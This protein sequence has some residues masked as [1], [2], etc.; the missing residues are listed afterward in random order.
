VEIPIAEI[1]ARGP[2]RYWGAPL[3]AELARSGIPG[4]EINIQE[5]H[6]AAEKK[7]LTP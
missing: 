4:G 5:F 2:P 6:P 3:L 1:R 7:A